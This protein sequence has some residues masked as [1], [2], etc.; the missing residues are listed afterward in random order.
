MLPLKQN[1]FF[2][3]LSSESWHKVSIPASV[4]AD[5]SSIVSKTFMA[6]LDLMLP[7]DQENRL[8]S[9]DAVYLQNRKE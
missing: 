4:T 8:W 6:L 5:P 1:H 2:M 9:S 3:N 7:I